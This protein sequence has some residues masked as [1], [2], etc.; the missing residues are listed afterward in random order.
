METT[1]RNFLQQL[2]YV[3]IGFSLMGAAPV[4]HSFLAPSKMRGSGKRPDQNHINAWLH[5]LE[6]GKVLIMS[7]KV[8]LGQGL[9]TA[10]KQIAAEEL[11][12]RLDLIEMQMAETGKTPDEG[13]TAGSYSIQS[14]GMAIRNAA[15]SARET[16]LKMASE[17]WGIPISQLQLKDGE[18]IGPKQKISLH[19]LL[20]GR[21][22][23][24]E[25]GT[26]SE[27]K[28]KTVRR[29]VGKPV[30][31][32]DI[33]DMVR[34][35]PIFVQDLRFPDMV[36]ARTVRPPSYT[37]EF[38]SMNESD[39]DTQPGFLKL[40][41]KGNFIGILAEEEYQ[42]I[43]IMER[44]KKSV[45][46]KSEDYLPANTPLKDYLKTLPLET[47]TQED[48]GD[49]QTAIDQSQKR[50]S[51]SYFKPYIMHA[52]N[53][54]SCA[55]AIFEDEKLKI[56]SH[57]QGIYPLRNSL[58][59]LFKMSEDDIH[60]IGVPGSGCYGHNAADDA[61]TEAALMAVE[62]PGRHV[63]L[64]WMRDDENG[65]EPYGTAMIVELKAGLDANGKINGWQYEVWSDG[66][67]NRP[68]GTPESLLP[69]R[70]LDEGYGA[71]GIGYKGG[72]VRNSVPYYTIDAV[73]VQSHIFLGPL[74]TSS[75]RALGAYAN[76]FALE[77]FMDELAHKADIDPIEFRL[78]HLKDPRSID[79]LQKLR[80]NTSR[81]DL[82]EGEGLGYAFC[83]YKNETA[84]F[85]VAAHVKV[86]RKNGAVQLKKMWAVIDAGETINPDG[87]KNQT[88]GGMIQSASWALKE[89]VRYDARHIT[90]LDWN[91]YPILRFPET[92]ETEVEVIDR[93]DQPPVGAGEVAQGPATAAVINAIFNTT[94]VRIRELP[95]TTD[96][97]INA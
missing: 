54:P 13:Y 45:Q 66:H 55:V 34:G 67:S 31:R 62:Y 22:I 74:R 56:W 49:A 88:E 65:W 90:S 95:V 2:G 75:L 73:N 69:A 81:I 37:S 83:H 41:R 35:N 32:K 30:P 59:A 6:N 4:P 11:D 5:L 79:C 33:E 94:G 86:D 27:F 42:T 93:P 14:S 26:P 16:V 89:A 70:F 80:K 40:V 71:P 38:V 52:P 51:A 87:L 61:A 60:I 18:V 53:G 50:H 76:L 7:G 9:R 28:G 91:S 24:Q 43:Q 84:Y 64:Q 8:E 92:P 77:C 21:Q 36:H 39:F 1:R 68:D 58:A 10:L 19:Q 44:A 46:W 57:S 29:F 63:R 82:A 12:T 96:A 48:K 23:E 15:A 3:S 72:A 47:K 17:K 85:A 97:L 20:A 25:V 78:M